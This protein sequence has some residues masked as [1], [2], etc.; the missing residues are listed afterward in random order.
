M[1]FVLWIIFGGL[2]GWL[3]SLLMNASEGDSPVLDIIVGVIGALAGGL[4]MNILGAPGVTGF[5]LYSLIVAL[6]GAVILLAVV[7]AFNSETY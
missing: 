1:D 7:R 2:T 4:V 6:L 5:N 3:A